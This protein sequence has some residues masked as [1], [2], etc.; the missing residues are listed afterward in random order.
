[1]CATLLWVW[2]RGGGVRGCLHAH[3]GC[4][5]DPRRGCVVV[6]DIVCDPSAGPAAP[7][8][9]AAPAGPSASAKKASLQE[10]IDKAFQ[11]QQEM[12]RARV[13]QQQQMQYNAI[14]ANLARFGAMPG[15]RVF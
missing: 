12:E 2:D 13:M 1:L 4:H 10:S 14:A 15:V 9:P 8:A 6:G 11:A 7:A 3:M 5:P